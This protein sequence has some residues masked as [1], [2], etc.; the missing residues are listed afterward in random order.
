MYFN[1]ILCTLS[2][3]R[4]ERAISDLFSLLIYTGIH[5]NYACFCNHSTTY[6][7]WKADVSDLRY[8]KVK[9]KAF[10][11]VILGRRLHPIGCRLA[12]MDF[13]LCFYTDEACE[14]VCGG[15]E[16]V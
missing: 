6:I 11:G 15:K 2:A 1:K 3:S 12:I 9:P 7:T 8:R 16:I 10:L 4:S 5:T 14:R 13:K